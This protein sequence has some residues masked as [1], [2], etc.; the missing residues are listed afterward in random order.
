LILGLMGNATN[1]KKSL[2]TSGTKE[3]EEYR[4]LMVAL[5]KKM[6]LLD[7]VGERLSRLESSQ[8]EILYGRAPEVLKLR[9]EGPVSS[10]RFH[11]LGFPTFDMAE[12]PCPS[13]TAASIT[14]GAS[15]PWRRRSGSPLFIFRVRRSSGT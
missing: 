11:K 13:S 5:L 4:K 9:K 1:D 3:D 15:A 6:E 14:S 12:I 2:G 8:Q 10:T 7:T